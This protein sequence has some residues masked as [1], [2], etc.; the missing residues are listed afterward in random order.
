MSIF[1]HILHKT[2]FSASEIESDFM[3]GVH[4][5]YC[6]GINRWKQRNPGFGGQMANFGPP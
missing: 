1:G 4:A 5:S 6:G 2:T 3:D